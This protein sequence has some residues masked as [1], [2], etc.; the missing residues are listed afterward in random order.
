MPK[1]RWPQT[2]SPCYVGG[3]GLC[4]QPDEALCFSRRVP[5]RYRC[6]QDNAEEFVVLYYY[7]NKLGLGS[8]PSVLPF[9]VQQQTVSPFFNLEIHT[10]TF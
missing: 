4:E 5:G 8:D 3:E 2:G 10:V 1:Q 7:Y 9:H 6:V